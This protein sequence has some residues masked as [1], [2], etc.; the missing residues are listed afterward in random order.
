MLTD[1]LVVGITLL[2]FAAFI[3]GQDAPIGINNIDTIILHLA[4]DMAEL[5]LAFA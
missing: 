1:Y 5:L 3:P 2:M 4:D